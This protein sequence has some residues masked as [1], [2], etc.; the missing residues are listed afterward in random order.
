MTRPLIKKW[1]G[2]GFQ[3][4]MY[5]DDGFCH[6]IDCSK[7]ANQSDII[8]ND[9]LNSG[10]LPNADKC[11]WVPVQQL[12]FLGVYFNT[13]L[14]WMSIPECRIQ[15][16]QLCLK[17]MFRLLA[18][19]KPI[20]VR[21]LARFVGQII[22]MN[23]VLGN[24]TQL[25]T[26]C[27]S[28]LISKASSWNDKL[29]LDDDCIQQLNFWSDHLDHINSKQ[30][31]YTPKCQKIVY[32]DASK[33]GYG[34][35]CVDTPFGEAQGNWEATESKQSS[36]WRELTAV[37]RVLLSI[38]HLVRGSRVKWFSDNQ[39]VVTIV[40]KGSMHASLQEIALDI[41]KLIMINGITLEMQWIPRD[42]NVFA[43]YLSKIVDLDDWG[44][45]DMIFDQLSSLW[46]PF[47][48]DW[49][50]S[51]HNH[52]V[53]TFYSRYWNPG[54]TGTDAFSFHWGG[55]NGWFVPP[56]YLITRVI[57]LMH[58]CKAYGTVIVPQWKSARFWPFLCPDGNSFAF[59]V[60]EVVQL[61]TAERFYTS[62]KSGQGIFGNTDLNFPMLALRI[63]FR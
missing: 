63:D 6:S 28:L 11:I 1:R 37:F 36:T 30:I 59:Y 57:K 40:E 53:P 18:I 16:L 62:S 31:K 33:V 32:S 51:W 22:S 13:E 50:A 17:E 42:D 35:Y 54:S 47:E 38:V 9:L 2:A 3:A 26:K 56:V 12:V 5:L 25:M 20:H 34:G 27:I 8:R 43:D 45:S 23:I 24:I 4:L 60:K 49:F 21:M 52:K 48:V 55:L 15:K 44:V 19:C 46:G 29:I 10:F 61:E 39:G 41:F 14:G 7:L 58:I